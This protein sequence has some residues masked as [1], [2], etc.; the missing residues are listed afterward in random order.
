MCDEVPKNYESM[1]SLKSVKD[2]SHLLHKYESD[3]STD[4]SYY[5]PMPKRT[6]S[7]I[8][9]ASCLSNFPMKKMKEVSGLSKVIYSR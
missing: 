2:V 3:V 1:A 8:N 9:Q 5:N 7:N 6:F 4:V